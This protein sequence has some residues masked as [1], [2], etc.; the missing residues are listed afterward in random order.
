MLVAF[1][2]FFAIALPDG[3]LGVAWPSM[4]LDFGVPIGAL[5]VMLPF[6]VVCSMLS[7][8]ATGFVLGRIGIGWLLTVSTALAATALFIQSLAAAFWVVVAASCLFAVGSGAI[9]AGLNA[10]VARRFSAR[11]ITWLHACYGVGAA[12]GPLIVSGTAGLGLSWRWAFGAVA[13]IQGVLALA[14]MVTARSW[15]APIPAARRASDGWF[16]VRGAWPGVTLFAVY[17]GLEASASLWAYTYLTGARGLR[18]ASA[19]LLVSA[20]WLTLVMGRVAL[21]PIADRTGARPMLLACFGG[22][23]AGAALLF[24]PGRAAAAGI[25][26]LALAAAPV[27]PLL[28]LTTKDRVGAATSTYLLATRSTSKAS[29]APSR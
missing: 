8:S 12:C 11:R 20:Y 4:R 29:S 27:F 16:P 9:D 15:V 10:H 6:A 7:S 5:G 25:L 17:T 13:A 22:L 2:A 3:V 28:T 18:P 14:F 26:M 23:T 21:G 24:L 19:A 1:L